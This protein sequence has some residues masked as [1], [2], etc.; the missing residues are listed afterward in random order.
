MTGRSITG[1]SARGICRDSGHCPN[2]WPPASTTAFITSRL[3]PRETA[4][5]VSGRPVA[6]KSLAGVP[7]VWRQPARHSRTSS[8]RHPK[9]KDAADE[10]IF[11][12]PRSAR[13]SSRPSANR[14]CRGTSPT[15]T[16]E[17]QRPRADAG[18]H[19]NRS[20]A[21]RSPTREPRAATHVPWRWQVARIVLP[22]AGADG[23][24]PAPPGAV[25]L[26]LCFACDQANV[27]HWRRRRPT[28]AALTPGGQR[29]GPSSSVR[30]DSWT[31]IALL[32][33]QDFPA[34]KISLT[35]GIT[36]SKTRQLYFSSTSN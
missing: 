31:W 17:P 1:Q 33:L 36:S 27:V 3:F 4:A 15:P 7:I 35:T 29:H 10:C 32:Q 8:A 30:R 26:R 9:H 24:P 21:L 28:S 2:S 5:Y 11:P 16:R 23:L 22:R 13:V 18:R 25:R 14:R 12:L 6:L 19:R 34:A 20:A